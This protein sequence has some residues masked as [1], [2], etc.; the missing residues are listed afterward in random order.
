MDYT[1][2]SWVDRTGKPTS[3]CDDTQVY[4]T[5][6][7]LQEAFPAVNLEKETGRGRTL[8]GDLLFNMQG[9]YDMPFQVAT[10]CC[11]PHP[12]SSNI[13]KHL[14][15]AGLE[16]DDFNKAHEIILKGL[17]VKHVPKSR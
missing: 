15:E 7:E 16:G 1:D 5:L 17:R 2:T 11:S 13:M 6:K 14:E 8:K 12:H 3:E 10:G 9:H 4:A